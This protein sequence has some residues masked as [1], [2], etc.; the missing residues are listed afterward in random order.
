MTNKESKYDEVKY[1]LPDGC[2]D[3]IPLDTLID[4]Y[5][6][7][8]A[9]YLSKYYGKIYCPECNQ[10]NLTL[11]HVIK[12]NMFYLRAYPK[13][14]HGDLCSKKLPL[15][16]YSVFNEY[17]E[18]GKS[19]EYINSRLHQLIDVALKKST[20]DF[21]PYVI[22]VINKKCFDDEIMNQEVRDHANL[23]A[24]PVKSLTTPF[25][26]EDYDVWIMFYGKV[27]IKW[28]KTEYSYNL[29]FRH[30]VKNYLIC[31]MSISNRIYNDYLPDDYKDDRENVLI[32]F[33][34]IMQRKEYK[35]KFYNNI[36]LRF[37]N[38]LV[39]E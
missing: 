2:W 15:V 39:M 9:L 17:C 35:G 34:G 29:K 22:R 12:D 28:Q 36:S 11:V 30:P 21:N 23:K 24:I 5:N 14:E 16:S 4:L 6:A 7:D 20:I 25:S 10:V 33:A 19:N 8:K 31:R 18:S 37:S 1:M 32:S 13:Q 38:Y 26:D 3:S 27:N